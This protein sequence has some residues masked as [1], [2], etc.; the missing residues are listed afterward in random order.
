MDTFRVLSPN[1]VAYLDLTGSGNETAAHLLEKRPGDPDAL[2][3]RAKPLILRLYGRGEVLHP[4]SARFEE[5]APASPPSPEPG[6]SS[7]SRSTRCRPLAASRCR[8]WS[9]WPSG[10]RW[11]SRPSK[12]RRGDGRIPPAQEPGQHR[13][14]ADRPAGLKILKLR[15]EFAILPDVERWPVVEDAPEGRPTG[16]PGGSH[17]S[18][19][20]ESYRRFGRPALVAASYFKPG[21]IRVAVDL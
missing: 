15:P 20:E 4:G 3:L 18:H 19:F 13:R 14:S 21:P 10:R 6:R 1:E 17:D 11:S 5:L 12:R 9:W 7:S 8:R 16:D 2:L